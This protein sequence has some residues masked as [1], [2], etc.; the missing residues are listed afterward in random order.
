M[1]IS[2][3]RKLS[4]GC[5]A[6]ITLSTLSISPF[7][8]YQ[9]VSQELVEGTN[10]FKIGVGSTF[11]AGSAH[12]LSPKKKKGNPALSP[13]ASDLEEVVQLIDQNYA[14]KAS[15][16]NEKIINSA[17]MAMLHSLDPHSSFY[18]IDDFADLMGEHQ[19]EYFGT[20]A[21]IINAT[22]NGDRE[23]FVLSTAIGSPAS[24]AGLR[25]GDRI[26]SVNN[27]DVSGESS[28][29]VREM[30]RGK[31][32]TS[33]VI[34]VERSGSEKIETITVQRGRI[35]QKTIPHAFM[36][37]DGMGYMDM[38]VGFSYATL[39]EVKNALTDLKIK[40]M[41]SLVIDLRGNTGGLIDQAAAVAELFLDESLLIASQKGKSK[42]DDRVWR[43]RNKNP[44]AMPLVLLVDSETA[45]AAEVV[46]GA[47]QDNDRALIIGEKTFGKGLVQNVLELPDGSGL[48]LTAAR[49]YTPS[50]RSIQ[51]DYTNTGLYEYFSQSSRADAVGISTTAS[52]TLLNRRV[53][54]GD[55]IT[56]DVEF[57]PAQLSAHQIQL[58]DLSLSF[59]REIVGRSSDEIT[60]ARQN[61]IF[62]KETITDNIYEKFS[63][64]CVNKTQTCKNIDPVSNPKQANYIRSQLRYFLA[65]AAFGS[66]VAAK[67]QVKDDEIISISVQKIK[68]AADLKERSKTIIATRNNKAKNPPKSVSG[69][70]R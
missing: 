21:S 7:A 63:S 4:L 34:K 17:I 1:H 14:G 8:Q 3:L 9:E 31:L 20:G 59:I 28:I 48:T 36:L 44:E 12:D 39:D 29:K 60:Q 47:F 40:G 57:R 66:D 45:S 62:G 52:R 23:T 37:N 13:L 46:A 51:R 50:G 58:S 67:Q 5:L 6:T 10:N 24:T 43:S 25:F 15:G 11:D 19:N 41:T 2:W 68:E 70:S 32:G 18:T 42:I 33:V 69:G 65:L 27:E 49:Y 54:G 26:L 64:F 30:I 16:R 53:Y 38:T 56:P 35:E 61:M 55:G 22:V